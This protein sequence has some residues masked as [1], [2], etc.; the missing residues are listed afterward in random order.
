MSNTYLLLR[1]NIERG[2]FTIDQ[3]LQEQLVPEDLLWVEGKSR[4]WKYLRE[5]IDLGFSHANENSIPFPLSLDTGADSIRNNNHFEKVI[6]IDSLRNK[7]VKLAEPYGG[8]PS[9]VQQKKA[10]HEEETIEFIYHKSKKTSP[11]FQL[12][13][14]T[15]VVLLLAL[16]WNRNTTFFKAK[17]IDQVAIPLVSASEHTAMASEKPAF[18]PPSKTTSL[19]D[20]I[21]ATPRIETPH[22]AVEKIDSKPKEKNRPTPSRRH[23]KYVKKIT[24][25]SLVTKKKAEQKIV[26]PEIMPTPDPPP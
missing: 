16:A 6:S 24:P 26:L 9:A 4:E 22:F 11:V 17:E 23:A 1:N 14:L 5:V 21:Q 15:L 19:S 2:P 25:P 10:K 7:E 20:S 8:D 12:G 13:A 3:L 18:T